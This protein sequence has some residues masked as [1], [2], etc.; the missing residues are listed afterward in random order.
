MSFE[1]FVRL[2]K[3][4][5]VG[6]DIQRAKALVKMSDNGIATANRFSVDKTSS[7]SIFVMYYESLREI[8]EAMA[9]SEGYKIYSH[10]AFTAYLKKLKE[11]RI[12]EYFDRFRKLRNG[13]NYYGEAI[14]PEIT[15]QSK[16]EIKK[17][18]LEL[19]EKYF[20]GLR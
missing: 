12:A 11:E 19:K 20:R 6:K 13:A 18:C 8:I 14:D 1:D 16:I 4:R 5:I 3:I 2:K 7:S 15:K 9:F 10:E 17:L